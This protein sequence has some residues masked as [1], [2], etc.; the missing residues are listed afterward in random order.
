MKKKIA[1]VCVHNSCRSQIA[2]AFGK[3]Y[4][5]DSY[6]CYSF[7]SEKKNQINQDA[8][9]IMKDKYDIDMSNQ[10]SKLFEEVGDCDIYISMG[11]NVKCPI[12]FNFDDNWQLEDP[13]GQSDEK[14]IEIIEKIKTNILELKDKTF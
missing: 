11:C 9:R 8:L 6:D 7:G 1:F 2:E 12:G 5:S 14:F 4:L 10:Y 13:S 3:K